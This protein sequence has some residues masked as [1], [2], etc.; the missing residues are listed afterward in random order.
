V[1][2]MTATDWA[3]LD[4][5]RMTVRPSPLLAS[6]PRR[7]SITGSSAPDRRTR[8]QARDNVR[9]HFG[10]STGEAER[11]AEASAEGLAGVYLRFVT[12]QH[13]STRMLELALAAL[14]LANTP[15]KRNAMPDSCF[16]APR[17]LEDLGRPVPLFCRRSRSLTHVVDLA[18]ETGKSLWIRR[19]PRRDRCRA[20][21]AGCAAHRLDEL[22]AADSAVR[23]AIAP[24]LSGR[25]RVP[26][27]N[28]IRTLSPVPVLTMN[29]RP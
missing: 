9:A 1:R 16:S 2:S 10:G 5:C 21:L 24:L 4:S 14:V 20:D 26:V 6:C 17:D 8:G 27:E 19:G 3:I 13:L 29:A 28:S 12:S 22:Q 7:R 11:E 25:R 23:R 15:T 18:T